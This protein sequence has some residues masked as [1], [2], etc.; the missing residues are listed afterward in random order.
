MGFGER[1]EHFLNIYNSFIPVTCL[2]DEGKC[3]Y[4]CKSQASERTDDLRKILMG[5]LLVDCGSTGA[6]GNSKLSETNITLDS[7]GIIIKLKYPNIFFI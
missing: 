4:S 6:V 7:R 1:N 2:Y 5:T 3:A